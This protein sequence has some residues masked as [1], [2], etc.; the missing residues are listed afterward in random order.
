MKWALN[1]QTLL[2]LPNFVT[3]INTNLFTETMNIICLDAEFADNEELLELSIFNQNGEEFYHSYYK[4][5]NIKDWRTDIHHITPEMV[6]D[7][8]SFSDEIVKLQR[9][10]EDADLVTGFAVDNDIRVLSH[11]GIENLDNIT[12][13]D[14]KD[15]FWYLRG[16]KNDMSPFSVPSLIVC[17]NTIG[18]EFQEDIAHSASVDTEFTL[19]CFNTLLEEY[20]SMHDDADTS[21]T[22]I[23]RMITDIRDAKA[24]YVEEGAKG[25]VRVFKAGDVYRIKYG[26]LQAEESEKLLL[27][28]E[29]ADRYKAEYEL[30]KMLR[31]KEVPGKYS[32]YKL[33]PKLLEDI[34]KYRNTYDAEESAWC[35]KI[36]RNLSRLT[37]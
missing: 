10:I 18:I 22:L 9:I 12:I 14:V 2:I 3:T 21:D 13:L 15:M 36:I 31:K 32:T 17:A 35:K 7:S 4:P 29:V 1:L 19:K 33:T 27:E 30:R 16:R 26:H 23:Q 11:S 25:Y 20:A 34:K 6:A 37:L 28:V 8:P 24:I 5:V